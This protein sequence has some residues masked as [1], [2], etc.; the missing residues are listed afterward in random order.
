MLKTFFLNWIL[1]GKNIQKPFGPMQV[2]S[3][4]NIYYLV[5]EG[6]NLVV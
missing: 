1:F 2:F 6:S 3:R 4:Q 5:D